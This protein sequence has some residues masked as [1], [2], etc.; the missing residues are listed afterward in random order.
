M[1]ESNE[2]PSLVKSKNGD[3]YLYKG[4]VEGKFEFENLSKGRSG[5]LTLEQ[6]QALFTIPLNL[7]ELAHENPL[8]ISLVR[9]LK[10]TL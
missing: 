6:S 8:I 9:E 4:E 3:I 7:I 2:S 5:F 10:L 1:T